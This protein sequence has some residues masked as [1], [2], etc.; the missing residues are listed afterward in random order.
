MTLAR[1]DLDERRG[2]RRRAAQR[3]HEPQ[4]DGHQRRPSRP[5]PPTRR[6]RASRTC[7]SRR[8]AC[9]A[10]PRSA[11]TAR[12]PAG[13]RPPSD[14]HEALDSRACV[15]AMMCPG[16]VAAQERHPWRHRPRD[17][18]QRIR[19]LRARR[20][21]G[22]PVGTLLA[23][24]SGTSNGSRTTGSGSSRIRSPS[25]ARSCPRVPRRRPSSTPAWSGGRRVVRVGVG[26]L[27][28][29]PRLRPDSL[30]ADAGACRATW[31]RRR[32]GAEASVA[33]SIAQ[34]PEG[35]RDAGLRPRSTTR[36]TTSRSPSSRPRTRVS[37]SPTTTGS[38]SLGALARLVA[39]SEPGR[40]R[41]GQHREQR[42]GP[43]A[44][45]RVLRLL[46]QRRLSTEEG[47]C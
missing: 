13:R 29:D 24:A 41:L 11:L 33:Y 15:N 7:A 17:A 5:P 35:R 27:R 21:R 12:E 10:K 6:R 16:G 28:H 44:D 34:E 2:W 46:G 43:R 40:R 31:T 19:A 36:R 30:E 38:I 14:W 32:L 25:R 20:G 47:V 37:A 22:R 3:P 42:H 39:R 18:A 45:R 1:E 8:S 9:S 4:R 26:L 23:S